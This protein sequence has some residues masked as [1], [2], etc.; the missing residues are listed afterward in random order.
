MLDSMERAAHVRRV[1]IVNG[2]TAGY[3]MRALA[4]EHV[5]TIIVADPVRDGGQVCALGVERP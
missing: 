3:L 1:Q 2:L 5:G 4:G